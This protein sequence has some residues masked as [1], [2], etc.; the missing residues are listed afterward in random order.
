MT[1][2]QPTIAS[3]SENIRLGQV[4]PAAL[5]D[6][7]LERVDGLESAVRAWAFLDPNSAHTHAEALTA[8]LKR[9][10]YRG[11]LHGIPLGIKDIIDVFDWPTA[12]GSRLW[13][14]N[15]ARQDAPAVRKL[16][17]AG[18]VLMGK[19][20]TTQYASFDPPPTRNPWNPARTP[21]GSSSGSA[22]AIACGMCLGTLGS[23]KGGSI[24]RPASFCGVAGCKPTYGRVSVDGVMPLAASMDHPGPIARSVRDLA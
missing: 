17:A 10:E 21:G 5:L 18:A 23:Q 15:I 12:C 6:S 7:C 3:A 24:P 14:D 20:V 16:R 9:G 13:R 11:P 8:E 4:T 19:T 2:M 22:A 1:R